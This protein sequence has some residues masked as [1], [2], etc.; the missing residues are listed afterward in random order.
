VLAVALSASVFVL[1]S[2]CSRTHESTGA[3]PDKG[4]LALGERITLPLTPLAEIAA[5]PSQY[6]DR[7]VATSGQVTSVCQEMGCWMEVRDDSGLA[8]VR[9]H[10]HT[11]FVP[12]TASGH[13]ARVQATVVRSAS[14]DEDCREHPAGSAGLAKVELDATGVEL[15]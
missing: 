6:A 8:H 14:G 3:P 5:H 12:R 11:F 7:V 1:M 9:M 2:A 13:V 4:T 15:D 10:G